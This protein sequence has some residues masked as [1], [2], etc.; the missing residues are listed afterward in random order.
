LPTG[1]KSIDVNS[2]NDS[3]VAY[4]VTADVLKDIGSLE[5]FW[6]AEAATATT[7]PP[8]LDGIGNTVSIT[9]YDLEM[10]QKDDGTWVTDYRDAD[11]GSDLGETNATDEFHYS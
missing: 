9:V 5:V 11:D 7:N 3:S 2:T 10:Y 8:V 1:H 4:E 6:Q